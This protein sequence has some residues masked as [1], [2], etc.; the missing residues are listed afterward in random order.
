MDPPLAGD[1]SDVP[2]SS[3][4]AACKAHRHA[5]SRVKSRRKQPQPKPSRRP[6]FEPP[7]NNPFFDIQVYV[8]IIAFACPAGLH[9]PHAP[10]K[11]PLSAHHA[12]SHTCTVQSR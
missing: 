12:T 8:C 7:H 6:V 11:L 10:S 1:Y 3:A 4:R 2:V 9:G 5:H